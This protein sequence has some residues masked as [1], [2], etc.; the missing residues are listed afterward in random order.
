MAV[1]QHLNFD[2]PGLGHEFLDEDAVIA[3]TVGRFVLRG[4]EP[5]ADLV[6]LPRDD[7][8]R[9]GHLAGEREPAP[10]AAVLGIIV[11]SLN[12]PVVSLLA[13]AHDAVRRWDESE[14]AAAAG[15]DAEADARRR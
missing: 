8:G 1:G 2:V 9:L 14:A 3:K 15:G 5:V 7:L 12:G 10:A 6:F 4:F 13:L 11:L